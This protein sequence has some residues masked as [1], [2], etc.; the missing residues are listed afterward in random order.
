[1]LSKHRFLA[2]V[3]CVLMTFSLFACEKNVNSSFKDQ[4]EAANSQGEE[5]NSENVTDSEPSYDDTDARETNPKETEAKDTEAKDTEAKET[6]AKG[7]EPKDTEAKDTEAKETEAKDTESKDTEAKDTEPEET[8]TETEAVP[9]DDFNISVTNGKATVKSPKGLVYDADGYTSVGKK[10]FAFEQNL[11]FYFGDQFEGTINRFTL[12]YESTVALKLYVTYTENGSDKEEYYFLESGRRTFSGLTVNF[13]DGKNASKL[14][15]VRVEALEE[16][17]AEFVLYNV[18]VER[19]SVPNRVIYLESSRYK[20]GI[21]LQ[22]G[23]AISYMSDKECNISGVDNLIN[24]YDTGRLVQQSYYG[25][26][27]IEGVFEWGSFNGSDRWPYNPVQGGDKGLKSSRLIDIQI[28]DGRVYIKAQP[29]D[30]GK[31]GYI[32]PSY[33]EN[34][35]VVEDEFVRVDNRF[36]DFSGWE[37]PMNNQE[38]PAFYTISY[39]DAFVWY[40]GA[41]PWTGDTLS[42]KDDLPFW[43]NAETSGQCSFRIKVPNTETWC[44]WVNESDNYG[45]GLYVPNVDYLKAGRYNYNGT[46]DPAGSP[47][48]YVAPINQIQLVS[49]HPLEYSYIMAC[50]SIDEIRATFTENKD[51]TANEGLHDN[52]TSIRQQYFEGSLENIDLTDE[53]NL[54]KLC[55]P[56]NTDVSYDKTEGAA[57]LTV[58]GS[59]PYVTLDY[60]AGEIKLDAK[61]FKYIEIVYML[62]LSNS[63]GKYNSE[64]FICTGTLKEATSGKSVTVGLKRDGN[65]HVLRVNLAD[66]E[67]WDGEVN[68]IRFDFF[69]SANAGD[70]MY[71]KSINLTASSPYDDMTKI[72][73]DKAESI[74]MI[75]SF[76][77][78]SASFDSEKEAVKIEVTGNDPYFV[79]D[80]S[81]AGNKISASDYSKLKITYIASADNERDSY[82]AHLFVCAGDIEGP[83]ENAM[84]TVNGIVADGKVRTVE[85]DLSRLSYWTGEL[86]KL[87]VDFFSV[88]IVGDVFYIQSMELVK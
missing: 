60:A 38:I 55:Y 67:Y 83:S 7:T 45:I 63:L 8:E 32:T 54:N 58:K 62:P 20:L 37:H 17:D 29:M 64:L 88:G 71:V 12:D 86:H 6:E 78:S 15:Y 53:S 52:Y 3:L 11:M 77:C 18:S 10:G 27:A 48:N 42:K 25:T 49:F 46:K 59:D 34:T 41:K 65:Y 87:R 26:G 68:S 28:E 79:V 1:M 9:M 4:T 69:C 57:K 70:V 47:T 13:L 50:G 73:F 33:M 66:L 75:K 22:W 81:I 21:D 5:N 76:T 35:Y 2:L 74:D 43:G 30:W 85:I 14:K 36:V 61:D 19:I 82:S 80:Y 40:D 23:G 31:V 16:G 72:S 44:A 24:Y 51:F 56:H 84:V 39:L